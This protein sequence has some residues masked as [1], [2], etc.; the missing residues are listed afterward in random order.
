MKIRNPVK[1]DIDVRNAFQDVEAGLAEV[2]VLRSTIEE[3]RAQIADLHTQLAAVKKIPTFDK[4]DGDLVISG[5][6]R[7]DGAVDARGA[8]T[9]PGLLGGSTGEEPDSL[10]SP[11]QRVV[12]VNGSLVVLNGLSADSLIVRELHVL[13]TITTP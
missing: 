2:D 3:L 12:Q 11:A 6:L 1:A 10:T 8:L 5:N 9:A 13:Q 7:V 4:I